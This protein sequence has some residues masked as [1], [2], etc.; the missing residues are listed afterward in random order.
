MYCFSRSNME[1]F[2]GGLEDD[3]VDISVFSDLCR[4][5]SYFRTLTELF[6]C[7]T[8]LSHRHTFAQ[9]TLDRLNDL[10]LRLDSTNWA[11]Q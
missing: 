9:F 6:E 2:D 1:C 4:C 5:A 8:F 11:A 10:N 7:N 3:I